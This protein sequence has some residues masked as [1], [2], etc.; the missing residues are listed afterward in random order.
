M[1]IQPPPVNI[2]LLSLDCRSL[3]RKI[4]HDGVRGICRCYFDLAHA[5]NA[6]R[7]EGFDLVIRDLPVSDCPIE[8]LLL[9]R[10][11]I[12]AEPTILVLTDPAE[13][14]SRPAASWATDPGVNFLDYERLT[15]GEVS[16]ARERVGVP[17][18]RFF[19]SGNTADPSPRRRGSRLRW[20][21]YRR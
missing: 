4:R 20:N 8:E 6:A 3:S 21:G 17:S 5:A 19:P 2:L 14:G 1:L 13:G 7:R 10:L 9:H 11:R 12:W 16:R 18:P 15:A